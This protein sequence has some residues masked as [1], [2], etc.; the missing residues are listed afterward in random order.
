MAPRRSPYAHLL[1]EDEDFRRWYENTRRGS[2]TTA[3]VRFR[4]IGHVCRAYGTTPAALARMSPRE[5]TSFLIDVVSMCEGRGNAGSLIEDYVKSLKSWF[6]FNDVEVAAKRIRIPDTGNRYENERPPS[7]DELNRIFNCADLRARAAVSLMAFAGVRPGV[8]GDFR[9][10]DGL[11]VADLPELEVDGGEKSAEFAVVPARVTVRRPISKSRRSYFTFLPGQGCEFV[12]E[13][14]E[15]RMRAGEEVAQE[16]AVVTVS[17][18]DVQGKVEHP[19]KKR[20]GQHITSINVGDAVRT[21]IRAAGFGWRPYVLRRYFDVRLMVAEA[22]GLLIEDWRVFWMGHVGDIE[23]TYTVNKGLS[24]DVVERMRES[25]A[26]ASERHLV[27][28][29]G[30]GEVT[31]DEVMGLFNRQFLTVAGLS[32]QEIEGMGELSAVSSEQLKEIVKRKSLESLGFG[33]GGSQ[34][35][36]PMADVPEWIERGFEYVTSIPPD[37]AIVRTPRA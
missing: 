14:L 37:R 3:A 8:L 36:V 13:Y 19:N 2:P 7:P 23:H 18:F 10:T 12:R 26:K 28:L 1:Q 29:R 21:A 33:N 4:R 35:V 17:K 31:R 16:S 24:Q 25:Y 9:G 30:A 34:K 11:R 32:E 6:L 27:T 22:D 15:A 20:Y 5:A